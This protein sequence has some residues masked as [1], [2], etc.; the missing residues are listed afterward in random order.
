MYIAH[1]QPLNG[2][3]LITFI[4]LLMFSLEWVVGYKKTTARNTQCYAAWPSVCVSLTLIEFWYVVTVGFFYFF[5][6]KEIIYEPLRERDWYIYDN[7]RFMRISSVCLQ[8]VYHFHWLCEH[9]TPNKNGWKKNC[10]NRQQQSIAWL[11]IR[12]IVY[13][14]KLVFTWQMFNLCDWRWL[15]ALTQTYHAF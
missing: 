10:R 3:K 14:A 8:C 15:C 9:W 11:R 1:T 6:L 13:M 7:R 5:N 12:R 2:H 4:C